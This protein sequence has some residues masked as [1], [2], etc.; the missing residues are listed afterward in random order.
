MLIL[1]SNFIVD[2]SHLNAVLE[3]VKHIVDWKE[4]GLKLGLHYHTMEKIDDEQRGRIERCKKEMLA[5]WLQG[6]DDAKKQTWSTLVDAVH[7]IDSALAERIRHTHIE[8][9]SD[10]ASM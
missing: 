8:N 7:R 6:E 9:Q 2:I 5:A 4:L 10:A 3:S 1:K